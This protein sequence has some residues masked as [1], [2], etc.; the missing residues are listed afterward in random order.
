MV[1]INWTVTF[2]NKLKVYNQQELSFFR[3]AFQLRAVLSEQ[4]SHNKMAVRLGAMSCQWADGMWGELLLLLGALGW[5]L[6]RIRGHLRPETV[7]KNHVSYWQQQSKLTLDNSTFQTHDLSRSSLFILPTGC[8]GGWGEPR[9]TTAST[10]ASTTRRRRSTTRSCRSSSKT[11][12]IP[13]PTTRCGRPDLAVRQEQELKWERRTQFYRA[14]GFGLV[15][16]PKI[17]RV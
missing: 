5:V 4:W 13:R 7:W 10:T 12:W 6:G 15:W 8:T 9:I 3:H 11:L 14:T 1:Q 17:G 16:S 2:L